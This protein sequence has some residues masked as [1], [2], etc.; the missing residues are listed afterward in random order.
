MMEALLSNSTL[1]LFSIL[2]LG[3]ALGNISIKGISLG[4]SGVLFVAMVA[5]HYGLKIPDGISAIGTALFVYC[6][7][8]GVGN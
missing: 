7:G 8:L 6:V 5:G 4:S 3:L 1:V 2:F